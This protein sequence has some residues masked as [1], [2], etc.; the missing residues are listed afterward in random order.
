[1]ELALE[2]EI[3]TPSL[4]N[5]GHY[6]DD[7]LNFNISTGI[8]C[9]CMGKNT[10]F[11]KKSQFTAHKKTKSHQKWL[12]TLNNNKSNYF[13]KSIA[14]QELI[15][16]QQIIIKNLEKEI[17]KKD[18]IIEFLTNKNKYKTDNY[19]EINLIDF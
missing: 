17:S 3:Y 6:V 9:I 15:E 19:E 11:T 5:Q 10:T 14:Q 8:K 13:T 18:I 4:D 2:P 7:H 1:M 12:E 16:Q